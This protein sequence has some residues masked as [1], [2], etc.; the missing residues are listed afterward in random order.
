[1]SDWLSGPYSSSAART[2]KS[3]RLPNGMRWA[4]EAFRQC[5]SWEGLPLAHF[6]QSTES[7]QLATFTRPSRPHTQTTSHQRTLG[8][9]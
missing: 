8:Y 7:C 4:S 1:M 5:Q 2:A 3:V 9:G 6:G